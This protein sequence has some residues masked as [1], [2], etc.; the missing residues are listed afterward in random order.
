MRVKSWIKRLILGKSFKA[1][2]RRSLFVIV[3]CLVL[4]KFFLLPVR[5][6]GESMEPTYKNGSLNFINTLTYLFKEP[7]R[8]DI[9]A[10]KMAGR[11][12]MLL[13]R[14]IGLPYERIAFENG[15]LIINGNYYP[16]DY[17]KEK[18]QWDMQE[19]EVGK[20][21]YFVAG[22]NRSMPIG[23]HALGRIHRS[24]IIGGPLL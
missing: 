14:I 4:F 3:G 9:V 11:K 15:R 6:Q 23:E 16:E 17:V 18:G 12:V 5:I 21:E 20:D 19:V 10:I 22:D 24:K 7:A 1:T 13:K 8:G 2:F